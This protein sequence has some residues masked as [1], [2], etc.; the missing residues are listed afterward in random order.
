MPEKYDD[1]GLG[2]A[3][4]GV[5]LQAFSRDNHAFCLSWIAHDN[6][7]ANNLYNNGIT[8]FVVETDSPGFKVA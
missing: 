8:A 3:E 4:S 2:Y 1:V 5:F 7:C 6:R